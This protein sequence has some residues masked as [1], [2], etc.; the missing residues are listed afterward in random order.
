MQ[1]RIINIP[2]ENRKCTLYN[3]EKIGDEFHY[4]LN[5]PYFKLYIYVPS[6]HAYTHVLRLSLALPY[7]TR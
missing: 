6:T 4:S 3:L 5:S 2:R 7:E 1:D